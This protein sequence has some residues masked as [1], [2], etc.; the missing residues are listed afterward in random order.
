MK[1]RIIGYS[2][3]EEGDPVALLE[4]GHRQH[5]RHRPPFQNRAWVLDEDGRREHLGTTLECVRCDDGE[6]PDP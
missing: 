3:D 2:V 5:V 4:C 6:P 1:Q